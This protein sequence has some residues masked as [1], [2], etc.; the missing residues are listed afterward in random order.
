MLCKRNRFFNLFSKKDIFYLAYTDG[1][2]LG[3]SKED[4]K[5][6]FEYIKKQ[7]PKLRE[8]ISRNK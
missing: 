6:I 5:I 8:W 3:L 2:I 1:D 4:V 7:A